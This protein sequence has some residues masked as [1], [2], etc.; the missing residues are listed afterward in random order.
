MHPRFLRGRIDFCQTI[1]VGNNGHPL[2]YDNFVEANQQ[3]Y[4]S[5]SGNNTTNA[6]SRDM[7]APNGGANYMLSNKKPTSYGMECGMILPRPG[8]TGMNSSSTAMLRSRDASLLMSAQHQMAQRRALLG[9]GMGGN[10]SEMNYDAGAN[11][12][13]SSTGMAPQGMQSSFMRNQGSMNMRTMQDPSLEMNYIDMMYMGGMTTTGQ[14]Q[15][16]QE[17]NSSMN[18]NFGGM[19]FGNA[20]DSGLTNQGFGLSQQFHGRPNMP[21]ISQ[22]QLL[23]QSLDPKIGQH[24]FLNQNLD[25]ESGHR[26][27]LNQN[28]D[29]N[30]GQR[31]FLNQNLDSRSNQFSNQQSRRLEDFNPPSDS[32]HRRL[33]DFNRDSHDGK[34]S[35]GI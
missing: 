4:D 24:Q 2:L 10:H 31:Q 25:H 12:A 34:N 17:M 35:A 20:M 13:R 6:G 21:Q 1:S 30:I 32:H 18:A 27:F 5:A 8:M 14:Q 16:M 33:A 9:A 3:L 29:P 23:N 22:R 15:R 26:Q 28:L 19:Q 11:A 7:F